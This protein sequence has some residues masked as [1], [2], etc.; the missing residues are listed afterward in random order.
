MSGSKMVSSFSKETNEEMKIKSET[1]VGMR[2]HYLRNLTSG[3]QGRNIV[4]LLEW[5]L[6]ILNG[7]RTDLWGRDS[8]TEF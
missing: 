4:P 2:S 8:I 1:R 7:D 3:T 6:L 5:D